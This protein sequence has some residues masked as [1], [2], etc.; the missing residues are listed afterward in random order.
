MLGTQ[1]RQVRRLP[2]PRTLGRK[3][4]QMLALTVAICMLPFVALSGADLWIET[5][6]PK[7]LKDMGIVIHR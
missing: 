6:D 4:A 1:A 2:I 5:T 3:D 7:Q